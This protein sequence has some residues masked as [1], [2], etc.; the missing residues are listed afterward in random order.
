MLERRHLSREDVVGDEL[1]VE[2]LDWGS[3][4]LPCAVLEETVAAIRDESDVRRGC[5]VAQRAPGED[6]TRAPVAGSAEDRR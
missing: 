3:F 2:Y 4:V 1:R 6:R 5:V